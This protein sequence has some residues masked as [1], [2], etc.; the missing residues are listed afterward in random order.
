MQFEPL[1]ISRSE[2]DPILGVFTPDHLVYAGRMPVF[3]ECSPD[4]DPADAVRAHFENRPPTEPP[5]SLLLQST[6]AFGLGRTRSAAEAACSLV[7][8]AAAIASYSRAFGGYRFLEPRLVEFI[9]NWEV[10]HYR[11]SH[12]T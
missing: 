7:L 12:A 3:V 1:L 11:T 6:A 8:D 9:A 4:A 10:E 2:A 5:K